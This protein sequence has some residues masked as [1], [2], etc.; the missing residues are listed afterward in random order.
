[1]DIAGLSY[2]IEHGGE[3]PFDAIPARLFGG[4]IPPGHPDLVDL[5]MVEND[6]PIVRVT[7]LGRAAIAGLKTGAL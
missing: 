5:G 4:T 1:M 3:C 6:G 7:D 2:L